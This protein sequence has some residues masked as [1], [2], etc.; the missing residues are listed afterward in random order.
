MIIISSDHISLMQ[1][2]YGNYVVQHLVAKGSEHY[3]TRLIHRI[4]GQV[5]PMSQHKVLW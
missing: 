4:K 5:V 1:D 3:R 2:Q